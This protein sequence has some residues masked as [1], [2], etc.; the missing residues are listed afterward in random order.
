MELVL[1]PTLLATKFITPAPAGFAPP[2][3]VCFF[4]RAS[5]PTHMW[6][7]L[8]DSMKSV[9]FHETELDACVVDTRSDRIVIMRGRVRSHSSCGRS[10]A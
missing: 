4:L 1:R 6:W 5:L 10:Q 8:G 2:G 3:R 9:V 7:C